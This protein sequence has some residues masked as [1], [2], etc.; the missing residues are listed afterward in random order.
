MRYVSDA[1]S[2]RFWGVCEAGKQLA[3]EAHFSHP[4]EVRFAGSDPADTCLDQVSGALHSKRERPSDVWVRIDDD[5]RLG[6]I[7]YCGCFATHANLT[8]A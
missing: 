6:L 5:T 1:D 4:R 8:A 2:G 7:L 3:V